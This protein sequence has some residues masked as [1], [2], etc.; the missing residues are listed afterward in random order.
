MCG[1]SGG[2]LLAGETFPFLGQGIGGLVLASWMVRDGD[3]EAHEEQSP[4]KL[5]LV[6]HLG[7]VKL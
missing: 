4:V 5:P 7:L 2:W 3:I 1:D 6:H